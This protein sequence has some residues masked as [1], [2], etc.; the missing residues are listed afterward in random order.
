MCL[1]IHFTENPESCSQI[2]AEQS[3]TKKPL[4]HLPEKG[5]TISMARAMEMVRHYE[6][7]E[8]RIRDRITEIEAT[9]LAMEER[10][11]K[12]YAQSTDAYF[13]NR[14]IIEELRKLLP[15]PK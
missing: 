13:T 12:E 6:A 15:S 14:K 7:R 11:T 1:E 5:E 2:I 3:R 9:L 4:D 10:T 8:Q